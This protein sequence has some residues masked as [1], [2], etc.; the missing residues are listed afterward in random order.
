M[1]LLGQRAAILQYSFT[2][3][4]KTSGDI[5]QKASVGDIEL[6]LPATEVRA[7]EGKKEGVVCIG[8]AADRSRQC[9]RCDKLPVPPTC[10]FCRLPVKGE[11]W[12]SINMEL[13]SIADDDTQDSPCRAVS[14]ITGLIP[15]ASKS[16]SRHLY[17][18]VQLV[19]VIVWIHKG[20]HIR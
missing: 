13:R 9:P 1:D 3:T 5:A 10:A 6:Q 19:L 15:T 14:V 8:C 11:S 12:F 2:N 18:H 16:I 7:V 20:S 4:E 17:P